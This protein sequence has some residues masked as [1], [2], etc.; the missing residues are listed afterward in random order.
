M[1]DLSILQGEEDQKLGLLDSDEQP[2]EREPTVS[3][4]A[5]AAQAALLS[6]DEDDVASYLNI[7]RSS[8]GQAQ[9]VS[10]ITEGAYEQ[11][12]QRAARNSSSTFA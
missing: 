2:Q 4:K 11:R 7:T 5:V 10:D 9:E 12:K 3:D 1:T 8:R 6:S